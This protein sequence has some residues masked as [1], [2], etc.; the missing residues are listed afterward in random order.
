MAAAGWRP[1][2]DGFL[3]R[4]NKARILQA[5]AEAKGRPAADRIAHLKKGDM[6]SEAETLLAG[7]GWL[8]EPLR[9]PGRA[10]AEASVTVHADAAGDETAAD[11]GET[12]MVEE[13]SSSENDPA[14]DAPHASAAE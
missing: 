9:T 13:A 5:V 10:L 8:P 2:V 6:A 7:T 3:G 4:V 11:G 1:T 14:G 12:A